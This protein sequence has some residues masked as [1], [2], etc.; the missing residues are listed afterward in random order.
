MFKKSLILSLMA[1]AVLI[2]Q[3]AQASSLLLSKKS[4]IVKNETL[5]N[6]YSGVKFNYYDLQDR[7][8]IINDFL[9]SIELEYAL[10]PLKKERIGL[11][12]KKLSEVA[13]ATEMLFNDIELSI[14]DRKNQEI[15]ERITFLQAKSNMDFLDR[16][17]SLVAQFQDTHF[18]LQEKIARPFM[19][20]GLRL[21]R[22]Q[23]KIIVGSL[24]NKFLGM[25][26][27]ISGADFSGIKIGDEV[28]SID[29]IPVEEKIKQLK[30]YAA[31]SSEEFR[32]SQS[33]RSLTLRNFKY[34]EKNYLKIEFKNA[35]TFKMPVFVESSA[36]SLPRL[37]AITYFNKYKIPSDT[38]AIGM[39]FDKSINKWTDS[40]LNF[41]GYSTRKLHLNLKGLTEYMGDDGSPAVRTGY[42]FNKGKS[43]G[44]LQLL[45]FYTKNVKVGN[46][47]L[48]FLDA[49]RNFIIEL[50]DQ[51]LPLILDL[52]SN[53]G[54]SGSYP[55]RVL[56]MLAEEGV[57]YP[58]PT[59]GFRMTHYMRQIQEAGLYQE[60]V[61]EDQSF[62]LTIDELKDVLTTTLYN[63][64]DYTPMFTTEVI[65]FDPKV[66]GFKNKIVALVTA[67][68]ISACD[69]MSFL[70]QSTKR[71]TIIGTHS[72]GT[73]AGYLSTESLN[74]KWEDRLRVFSTTIPN[75]L[76][77]VPGSSFDQTV[78]GESSVTEMCSE[79]KP[80]IA[81]VQYSPTM[82]D[83][84]RNNLG[85]LQKAA[86]VLESQE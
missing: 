36:D 76:F 12:F 50:K 20:N 8:L 80:T 38:L 26:G 71:A 2:G 7:L 61:G 31:G 25:A 72:N 6:V 34:E 54:G 35:G 47:S 51:E 30:I 56:S 44:V 29:G 40:S 57:V 9:R 23:G 73:G 13:I 24:E 22:I 14:N 85:W 37:D 21:F 75:Y 1:S 62:G 68:C 65:P 3:D 63:K 39:T 45:T 64:S 79:N 81:E 55:P 53:G 69:K 27:K 4:K 41:E 59:T 82:V 49:I 78:F 43:Y 77:G 74:T 84:A 48:P 5:K 18:G 17:H 46:T 10:L 16:M 83:V 66:K 70:L 33:V 19:Y 15:V 58:G 67:D 28:I 52:R 60:V 42:Y 32:D 86:Q 11:D